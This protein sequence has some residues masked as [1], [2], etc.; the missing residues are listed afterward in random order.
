MTGQ[1]YSAM[2]VLINSHRLRVLVALCILFTLWWVLLGVVEREAGRAEQQGTRLMLN[3]IRSVLVVKGAEIRLQEGA[4]FRALAG[5]NPF[6]WFGS[7]PA[8]YDGTCHD[9]LPEPGR[10]CFKPLQTGDKGYKK[11]TA[12]AQ[13]QVIFQ[14]RQPI[15]LGDRQ[16]SGD[17]PMAWV[18]AVEFTDRNGNG[19]LDEQ[20]LQSGLRLQ[21]VETQNDRAEH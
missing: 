19:R 1:K 8:R 18:V 13:G 17:T 11:D 4:D 6:E 15:T 3:Q 2:S 12:G 20:D 14:P 10:W 7:E 16:G 5:R 9:G 21:P